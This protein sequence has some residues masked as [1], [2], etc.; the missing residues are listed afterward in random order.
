M[1]SFDL[2]TSGHRES[3]LGAGFCF[4]F[5]HLL[6]LLFIS[7]IY[8]LGGGCIASLH[9]CLCLFF[10]WV[11]HHDHFLSLKLWH[12]LYGSEFFQLCCKTQQQDFSPVFKHNR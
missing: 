11:D 6:L 10:L 2:A 3:L 7:T 5:W 9:F 8:S 4:H 12:L 1:L